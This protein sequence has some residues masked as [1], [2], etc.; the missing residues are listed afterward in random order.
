MGSMPLLAQHGSRPIQVISH[1][2]LDPRPAHS[3]THKFMSYAHLPVTTH[4][5]H[6]DPTSDLLH[7]HAC[8][9]VS[10]SKLHDH[11]RFIKT[12]CYKPLTC[13]SMTYWLLCACAARSASFSDATSSPLEL[14][15]D[16]RIDASRSS[17][18]AV[19]CA[20]HRI[21]GCRETAKAN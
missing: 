16:S 19:L 2:A 1:A 14:S 12:A 3:L 10:R 17:W 21:Q 8:R 20:L 11:T 9:A 5:T 6:F 7:P 15:V 4:H 13:R 18:V